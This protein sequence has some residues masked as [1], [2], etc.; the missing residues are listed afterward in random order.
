LQIKWE[1]LGFGK[2]RTTPFALPV[3]CSP[4]CHTIFR[5]TLP[6]FCVS[7]ANGSLALTSM[8]LGSRTL[9][10]PVTLYAVS[11]HAPVPK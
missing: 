4:R 11:Q 3:V 10:L 8:V 2:W 9:Q 1:E 6:D 5:R 7:P